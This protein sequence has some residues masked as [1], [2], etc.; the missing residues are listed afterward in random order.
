MATF[1][2]PI[3]IL[4]R[5][6]TQSK[7]Q[8]YGSAMIIFYFVTTFF[9]ALFATAFVRM[10]MQRLRIVDKAKQEERKIHKHHTPLGGGLAIF[11]VFAL[12]VLFMYAVGDIGQDIQ[13]KHLLGMLLAG[14]I[15]IIG[16]LIDDKYDLLP[17]QQFIAPILFAM[18]IL[19]FGIG[20]HEV[21]HPLGQG[22]I[23]L[24]RYTFSLGMFGNIIVL[25]DMLVF[26]W[27]MGM[28][29]TTKFL[30]G[31]DGLVTGIVIIGALLIVYLSLQNQWLQ[32]EVALITTVFAASCTGFLVWNWHP[33]KIFLGEGGSLFTGGM[34]AVLALLSGGKIATTLLVMSI[35]MLDVLRVIYR[36]F[37]KG[38]PVYKGDNEHL[39]FK[40]LASG[41]SQ[42]QA[43]L[44]MY[45][46]SLLFGLIALFLQ[47]NQQ[48]VALV[49]L[50]LVMIFIGVWFSKK[51]ENK[52]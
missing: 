40:L 50:L 27:L 49:L 52:V 12:V 21:S 19:L 42:K 41:L 3:S 24:D 4:R 28:M 9:F 30:D 45:T 48:I 1:L 18:V 23:S 20:P 31:L 10:L 2:F 35:P 13:G 16:G 5:L 47:S 6:A 32:P 7:I 8:Y 33:A 14:G 25:A 44:L 51:E 22:M 26:L 39:H 43:V 38:H 46:I 11:I 29:F 15:I 36:R 37:K 17:I 34:L